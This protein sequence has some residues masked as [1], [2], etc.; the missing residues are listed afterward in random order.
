MIFYVTLLGVG[1]LLWGFGSIENFSF[2]L[3]LLSPFIHENNNNNNSCTLRN[4][5]PYLKYKLNFRN[6][7]YKNRPFSSTH[8]ISCI[9]ISQ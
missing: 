4:L 5:F 3:E 6:L 7:D 8:N 2:A 1:R 9:S